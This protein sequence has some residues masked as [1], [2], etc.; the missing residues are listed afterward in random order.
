MLIKA[1][2]AFD[3]EIGLADG[4]TDQ[5]PQAKFYEKDGT[6]DGTANLVHDANGYYNAE[7]TYTGTDEQLKVR[8]LVYSDSYGGTLNTDYNQFSE[9]IDV[10][11]YLAQTGADSDTLETLSDQLDAV[12]TTLNTS[13]ASIA[14]ALNG[15]TLSIRRGDIFSEEISDLGDISGRTKLYFTGR[16]NADDPDSASLVQ[17]EESAGLLYINGSNTDIVSSNGSITVTD[18]VAGNITIV[19]KGV[20]TAKLFVQSAGEYDIQEIDADG[21]KTKTI[22]DLHVVKDIT[23]A[24]E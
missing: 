4:A 7:Y 2:T 22:G 21:P 18:E 11:D 24:T 13:A 17:I 19:L 3:Y 23:R 6:L 1:N 10:V 16:I 12:Q 20:E 14:A 9:T 8:V 15:S 5:F